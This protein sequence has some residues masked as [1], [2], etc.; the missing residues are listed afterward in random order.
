MMQQPP[1]VMKWALAAAYI[2]LLIAIGLQ[3]LDRGLTGNWLI[4]Q[5]SFLLFTLALI[6]GLPIMRRK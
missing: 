6:L 3:W 2:A 1:S 4:V 5:F